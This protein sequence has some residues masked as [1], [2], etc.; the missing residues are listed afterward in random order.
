MAATVTWVDGKPLVA[1]S[2]LDCYAGMIHCV[3]TNCWRHA[4]LLARLLMRDATPT[5]PRKWLAQ[6]AGV[7]ARV[8]RHGLD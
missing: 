2:H 4:D 1:M 8:E 3:N 5:T 6:A 7:V